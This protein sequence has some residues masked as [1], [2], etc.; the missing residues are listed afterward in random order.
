MKVQIPNNKSQIPNNIQ[1]LNIKRF[2]IWSFEIVC[3][4]GL[5]NW[6]LF[7]RGDR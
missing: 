3:N 1:F 6:C 5:G 7:L 4:S 2:G